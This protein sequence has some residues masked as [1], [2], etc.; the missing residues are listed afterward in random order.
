MN[1]NDT[2]MC[3]TALQGLKINCTTLKWLP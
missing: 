1:F 3:I 2:H